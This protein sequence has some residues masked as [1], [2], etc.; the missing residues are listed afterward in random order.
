MLNTARGANTL[1][2]HTP[3]SLHLDRRHGEYYMDLQP[4]RVV[5]REGGNIPT[6]E[7]REWPNGA[8]QGR[9][10]EI[11]L[12]YHKLSDLTGI[13][14]W[15]SLRGNL[16]LTELTVDRLSFPVCQLLSDGGGGKRCRCR[17]GCTC[18]H[19]CHCPWC[20]KNHALLSLPLLV[21][22]V[23]KTSLL[24]YW[25]CFTLFQ[26]ANKSSLY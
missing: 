3:H 26:G 5:D 10:F 18:G 8:R 13:K 1:L 11:Y 9:C 2:I 4:I 17:R 22:P 21:L 14:C 12:Q 25:H 23:F 6:T 15:I 19:V 7:E 24:P 20:W 16:C